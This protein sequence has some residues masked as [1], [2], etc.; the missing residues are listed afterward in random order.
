M[1]KTAASFL[2]SNLV[3]HVAGS[4][5]ASVHRNKHTWKENNLRDTK[6]MCMS[7]SSSIETRRGHKMDT[8]KVTRRHTCNI[9][10]TRWEG[11]K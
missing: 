1:Y 10:N 11:N 8:R 2:V 4:Y 9:S 6:P 3:L 5:V 7:A